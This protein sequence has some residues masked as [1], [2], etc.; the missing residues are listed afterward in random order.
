[1]LDNVIVFDAVKKICD[2]EDVEWYVDSKG[3]LWVYPK[4]KYTSSITVNAANTLRAERTYDFMALR[5]KIKVLGARLATV[6]SDGDSWTENST[7]GWSGSFDSYT[8]DSSTKKVGNYSLK[9]YEGY[10]SVAEWLDF[11]PSNNVSVLFSDEPINLEFWL[12]VDY[13]TKPGSLAVVIY[14]SNNHDLVQRI[15]IPESGEWEFYKLPLGPRERAWYTSGDEELFDWTDIDK[16]RWTF[17]NVNAEEE[18][19]VRVDGLCF[20]GKPLQ[21]EQSSSTSISDY[22]ERNLLQAEDSLSDQNAVDSYAARLL[23]ARKDPQAEI[24]LETLGA[25]FQPGYKQSV[26]LSEIGL[27]G[28][29]RIA[30]VTHTIT[31]QWTSRL[32]LKKPAP[33]RFTVYVSQVDRDARKTRIPKFVL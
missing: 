10:T 30:R 31:K 28:T 3:N 19:T 5:N 7:D 18:F 9:A 29:Y 4:N 8:S 22:G 24:L 1:M 2:L 20:S 17:L 15:S 11:E 23:A 33:S 27:T 32:V 16:I 25:A 12:R 13:T 14:D 21:K 26:S 6:P